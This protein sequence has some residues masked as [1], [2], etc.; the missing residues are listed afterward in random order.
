MKKIRHFY[1][2]LFAIALVVSVS[3]VLLWAF[4]SNHYE[5]TSEHER[6]ARE[7]IDLREW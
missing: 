6:H 7:P 5:W 2:K 1:A 3:L 4:W